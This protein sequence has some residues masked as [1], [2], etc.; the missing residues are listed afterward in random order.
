MATRRP[1]HNKSPKQPPQPAAVD[2]VAGTEAEHEGHE[3]AVRLLE[4]AVE[5]VARAMGFEVVL[6]EWAGGRGGRIARVYLD[7]P[8]G[9]SLDDCSRMSGV[10]SNA[11]DAAEADPETPELTALLS[12]P[13]TL[14]VSSPGVDRPLARLSHFARHVGGRAV[15]RTFHPLAGQGSADQRTFHGRIVGTEVDAA[16]PAD[17]RRG[18]VLLRSLDSDTIYKISLADI[19]RA[20]L[21]YSPP[22]TGGHG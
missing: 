11:L 1:T 2:D 17:D 18:T 20:N 3:G 21:V 9:V 15:V 8:N 4:A 14:E 12:L 5:P 7:H 19:R 16:D 13:Y 10:L 6:I 22:S